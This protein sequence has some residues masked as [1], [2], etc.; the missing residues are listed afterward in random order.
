MSNISEKYIELCKKN[1]QI[2]PD[3]YAEYDV[4][5]GLRDINGRGVMA[6]LTEIGEVKASEN[7]KPCRGK[8]YYHGYDIEDLIRG[9]FR[10]ASVK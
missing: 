7:G 6:G 4:K 1:K 8:L 9:A 3:L 10:A 5:R 2:N